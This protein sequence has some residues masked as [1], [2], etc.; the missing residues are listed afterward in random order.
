MAVDHQVHLPPS[1]YDPLMHWTT[2]LI[3]VVIFISL[4]WVNIY[5]SPYTVQLRQ[6]RDVRYSEMV[7]RCE[8]LLLFS[9]AIESHHL[10]LISSILCSF[11]Q[12]IWGGRREEKKIGTCIKPRH[13]NSLQMLL[14]SEW[15]VLFSFP[16]FSSPQHTN[17]TCDPWR[18]WLLTM[19]SWVHI[20][21]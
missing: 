16:F 10:I 11:R 8:L 9:M 21:L 17:A 19:T 2:S 15:E 7:L 12:M 13:R 5:S 14:C 18:W 4:K 3:P 1:N 6:G 20:L